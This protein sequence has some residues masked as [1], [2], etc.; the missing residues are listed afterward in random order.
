MLA[1][2]IQRHSANVKLADA[3]LVKTVACIIP[4]PVMQFIDFS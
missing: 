4:T 1:Y 2:R 3:F